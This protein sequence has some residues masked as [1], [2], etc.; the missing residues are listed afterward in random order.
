MPRYPLFSETLVLRRIQNSDGRT[1][2]YVNDEPVSAGFMREVGQLLVEIHGQHDDRALLDVGE[3]R[4]LLDAFGG[5]E[6]EAN[7]VLEAGQALNHGRSRLAKLRKE[8][9]NS[10][11]NADYLRESVEELHKLS[12]ES[13]EE[14]RPCRQAAT[15]AESRK[16]S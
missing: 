9:E 8:I 10:T 11:R 14:N 1:K 3:H 7:N 5:L 15:D 4:R 16:N 12:P 2:A 6:R 13:G